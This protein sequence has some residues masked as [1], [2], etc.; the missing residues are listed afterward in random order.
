[1][2]RRGQY[3][4]IRP[5]NVI[6]SCLLAA[7]LSE[8]IPANFGKIDVRP[9][10]APTAITA[11]QM[12]DGKFDE[13]FV[14]IKGT[15]LDAFPDDI[16]SRFH[17]FIVESDNETVYAT[18]KTNA[19][20]AI[21]NSYIGA[22]VSLC[23][24]SVRIRDAYSRRHQ[25]RRNLYLWTLDDIRVL[26]SPPDSPFDVEDLGTTSSLRPS[27]IHRLGRR[28]T[29]GVVLAVWN[30]DTFLLETPDGRVSR[31]ELAG[32][33][34]PPVGTSVEV[35]G[36]PETDTYCINFTRACWREIDP[37]PQ[38]EHA[39][40]TV[41]AK[42]IL[43]DLYG[44]P[45]YRP[46]YHGQ[47]IRLSGH[48]RSIP[49]NENRRFYLEDGPCLVPVDA[50][51]A[52]DRMNGL[53]VGSTVEVTGVCVMNVE[54]W[55]PS[56]AFP[57]I[58]GF[59]L[60]PRTAA[61]IVVLARPP[62]WTPGRLAG[63]IG[64][65]VLF[66]I[67]ILIWNRS[68]HVLA[69]RRGRALMREQID[70]I[71]NK[72]KIGERTRLAVELHDSLA[73][74]LTGITFEIN[75][76]NKFA[77]ENARLSRQ[78][79]DIASRILKSC[80]EEL[81]NCLWELRSNALEAE[82]MDSAIRETLQPHIAEAELHVRFN[83]PR[84]RLSDNTAHALLRIIR[85]LVS[86]AVRHGHATAIRIAGSLDGDRLLFSVADNGCGFDPERHPGIE[87]GHFGLQGVRE[88]VEGQDGTMTVESRPDKGTKISISLTLQTPEE[89]EENAE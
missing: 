88:R 64:A 73:Q 42:T 29:R 39:I 44:K 20:D 3:G 10:K 35:A 45:G 62:W 32:G 63:V 47:L 89:E 61:D 50:S 41:P 27:D 25:L 67:G 65:L 33:S 1:M 85:E 81:R 55:R 77:D 71:K 30:R 60:V 13:K 66:L 34:P 36:L 59:T 22:Q 49:L 53:E 84:Q 12:F 51:S 75:T 86:N 37:L 21:F 19:N 87:E 46:E 2:S 83:V 15:V 14:E 38:T 31:I 68:L 23:G 52:P 54:S 9:R 6:F 57:R 28:R 4:T 8:L 78:H 80:R 72:L 16:D 56:S 70:R 76:A 18:I 74:S 43:S 82:L 40:W 79:L 24:K 69:E 5:V 7:A 11:R 48:V 26:K 17:F 58:R